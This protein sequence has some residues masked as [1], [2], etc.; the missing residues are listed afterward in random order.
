[1]VV[2]GGRY[3]SLDKDGIGYTEK[4]YEHAFEKNRPVI[5]LLHKDPQKLA[6]EHTETDEAAWEKLMAFRAKLEQRHTCSYWSNAEELKARAIVGLTAATKRHPAVGWLRADEV[7]TGATIAEV[8]ALRNRVGDLEAQL[9]ATRLKPP[10]G[11]EDLHQGDDELT[12]TVALTLYDSSYNR[13]RYSAPV[14]VTWNE[15][16][17]AVAPTLI[18]EASDDA[19]T[20]AF[21]NFFSERARE[22]LKDD[23]NLEGKTWESVATAAAAREDFIIQFRA[24][25]LMRESSRPRSVKDT[26]RYWTLTPYGDELMTRPRASRRTPLAVPE[27]PPAAEENRPVS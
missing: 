8:L 14:R 12:V 9:A 17:A 16:F 26:T 6:R 15:V 1:M 20:S 5:P 27:Q 25:G 2:V 13:T 11:A 19:L 23:K 22:L 24:L 3:G 10:P 4:E 7:P 21:S 18:N